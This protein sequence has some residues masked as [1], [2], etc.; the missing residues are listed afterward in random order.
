MGF[1][2]GCGGGVFDLMK[3]MS[4]CSKKGD[5]WLIEEYDEWGDKELEG[6]GYDKSEGMGNWRLRLGL[7]GEEGEDGIGKLK[8]VGGIKKG[9]EKKGGRERDCF[10]VMKGSKKW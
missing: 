7:L 5:K 8:R 3:Y 2:D 4:K 6:I 10:N 9:K 1:G